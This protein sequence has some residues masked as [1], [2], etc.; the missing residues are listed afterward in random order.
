MINEI[1]NE[2]IKDVIQSSVPASPPNELFNDF[3]T[4]VDVGPAKIQYVCKKESFSPYHRI[5][6]DSFLWTP[7][8]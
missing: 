3:E 4:V 2:V 5:V 1:I 8:R 7:C 6:K